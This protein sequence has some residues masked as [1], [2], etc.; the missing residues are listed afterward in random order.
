MA[1]KKNELVVEFSGAT[2]MSA[3]ILYLDLKHGDLPSIVFASVP[4]AFVLLYKLVN[5]L[6]VYFNFHSTDYYRSTSLFK[7]KISDCHK[8]LESDYLDEQTRAKIKEQLNE[9]TQAY[10]KLTPDN[11]TN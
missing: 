1:K 8:M 6:T 5:F 3:I 4:A 7:N 11:V 9:A 10:I 2:F